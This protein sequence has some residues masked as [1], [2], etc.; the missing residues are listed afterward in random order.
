MI[1]VSG[2]GANLDIDRMIRRARLEEPGALDCLLENY[3]NFLRLLA[4]T[5]RGR[6]EGG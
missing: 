1:I 4:R 3:R 5:V 6:S 2:L